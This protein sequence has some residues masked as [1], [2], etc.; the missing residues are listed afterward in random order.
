MKIIEL[1][2]TKWDVFR[3]FAAQLVVNLNC[4]FGRFE[5]LQRITFQNNAKRR[6]VSESNFGSGYRQREKPSNSICLDS[7]VRSP[8]HGRLCAVCLATAV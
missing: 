4:P 7:T 2:A 6:S 5:P 8:F 1:P 3:L